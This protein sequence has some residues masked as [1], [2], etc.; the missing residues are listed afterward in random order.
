MKAKE[1]LNEAKKSVGAGL[2]D[3]RYNYSTNQKAK[4]ITKKINSIGKIATR[5]SKLKDFSYNDEA[6]VHVI[7]DKLTDIDNE[8]IRINM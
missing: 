8:I 2:W 5:L 7:F 6:K 3:T 4:L 1:Y